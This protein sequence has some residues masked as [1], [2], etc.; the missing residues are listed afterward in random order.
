MEAVVR[1][2]IHTAGIARYRRGGWEARTASPEDSRAPPLECRPGGAT[3]PEARDRPERPE[4]SNSAGA[5]VHARQTRTAPLGASCHA[6]A[7]IA[8]ARRQSRRPC[9]A[10][11][12]R[13]DD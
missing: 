8:P 1:P 6:V 9:Y 3:A 7:A 5:V 13:T 11:R 4:A 10:R 2:R 12:M